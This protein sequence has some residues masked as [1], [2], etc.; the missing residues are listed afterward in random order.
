MV[1]P[2]KLFSLEKWIA[3]TVVGVFGKALSEAS[4]AIIYLYTA[5][6]YPTVVRSVINNKSLYNRSYQCLH[7]L[8]KGV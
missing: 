7:V 3:R 8:L 6:L 2:C 5:E 4:C 1:V